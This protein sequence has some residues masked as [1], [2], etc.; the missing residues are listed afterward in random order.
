LRSGDLIYG[1]AFNFSAETISSDAEKLANVGSQVIT[2]SA[3]LAPSLLPE[4]EANEALASLRSLARRLF[5]W[6]VDADESSAVLAGRVI[7]HVRKRILEE[8]LD[9]WVDTAIPNAPPLIADLRAIYET[10]NHLILVMPDLEPVELARR[11]ASTDWHQVAGRITDQF[12]ALHIA[13]PSLLR[14]VVRFENSAE[15]LVQSY[16]H[17]WGADPIG[18]VDIPL[19]YAFRGLARQPSA[20]E[21]AGLPHA[22]ITAEDADLSMLI[23]DFQNKLLNIQLRSELLCRTLDIPYSIPE[24]ALPDRDSP[25][26]VRIDGILQHLG[27]WADHYAELQQTEGDVRL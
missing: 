7:G 18:D 13:T 6:P 25:A 19:A 5:G 20:L 16:H 9:D 4:K 27:W 26:N 17:A 10:D 15:Y 12:R 2:A 14:L 1:D 22:Y 21:I 23:H 24:D 8:S 11:I 3:A